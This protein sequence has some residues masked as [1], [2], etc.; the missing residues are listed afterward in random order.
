MT[1][2]HVLLA[3]I[4]GT[5]PLPAKTVHRKRHVPIVVSTLPVCDVAAP[6]VSTTPVTCSPPPPLD[7]VH[8]SISNAF[9]APIAWFD[10]LFFTDRDEIETNQSYMRLIVGPQW[11]KGKGIKMR[12][13]IRVKVRVPRLQHRLNLIFSSDDEDSVDSAV[14]DR[15]GFRRRGL[16][17]SSDFNNRSVNRSRAGLGYQLLKLIDTDVDVE[18]ALRSQAR[19]ELSLRVRHKIPKW[20]GVT[21]KL[22]VTGFWLQG[23]GFGS[24]AQWN[25][26]RPLTDR[27]IFHF[28]NSVTQIHNVEGVVEESRIS[29]EATLSPKAG[30]S[31]GVGIRAGTRPNWRASAYYASIVYRR[32]FFRDWLFYEFEPGVNWNRTPEGKFPS[33]PFVAL[34]FEAQFRKTEN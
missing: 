27:A 28:D 10:S 25:N 9:V 24:N 17:G 16:R 7:A 8:K 32:S 4:P 6:V 2:P 15:S 3:V 19:G 34:R 29:M 22:Y 5:A 11:V 12:R 20:Y 26:E 14:T 18:T 13:A 31:P 1:V 21:T 30:L 33:E 23:T